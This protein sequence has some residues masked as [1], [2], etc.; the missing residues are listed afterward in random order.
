MKRFHVHWTERHSVIVYADNQDEAISKAFDSE[1]HH[2]TKHLACEEE[3]AP[4][5]P[6]GK[7]RTLDPEGETP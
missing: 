3:A 1:S 7:V 4:K 6:L 2:E 5:P